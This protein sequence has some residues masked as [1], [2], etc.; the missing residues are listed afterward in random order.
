MKKYATFEELTAPDVRHDTSA[1]AEW[2]EQS[3]RLAQLGLCEG[4]QMDGAAAHSFMSCAQRC[5]LLLLVQ[6]EL[7]R[8][9][10]VQRG[11][12]GA[13]EFQ[14]FGAAPAAA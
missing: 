1:A 7:Q 5:A 6:A 8:R 10:V 9:V 2:H 12:A 14:R 4:C 13:L 11:E 3:A